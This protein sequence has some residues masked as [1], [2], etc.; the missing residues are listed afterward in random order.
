M[1]EQRA[2]DLALRSAGM[3][4][5]LPRRAILEMIQE[6]EHH[7][8]AEEV[9]Q[10]L[11]ERNLPLPRSSV[12]NVLGSLASAGLIGRVDTLPGPARFEAE[13][14]QHDHFWC[15]RCRSVI[16]VQRAD[17]PPV[18]LPGSSERVA[19]TYVGHC[20]GCPASPPTA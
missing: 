20:N 5:T 7:W 9:R 12:N 11:T 18:A 4:A 15:A 2:V 1:I 3:R 8:S 13:T 17:V 19:I 14:A 10:N 6:G 16:N